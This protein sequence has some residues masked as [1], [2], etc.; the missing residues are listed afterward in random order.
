E[1]RVP[2][3]VNN[4]CH[5]VLAAPQQSMKDY[6]YKNTDA[7]EMIFIHEGEGVLHTMYGDLSF[8]YGDY[9]VIPRGTIYQ[10]EFAGSN[11]RLFIVESFSPIRYPKRY[12]SK[13]GQLLEHSP[14]CERDIRGPEAL[15][16]YDET[17]DFLIRAKKKGILYGLHYGTHPFDLIGW[18]G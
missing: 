9:L 5:I 10:I 18:D 2:V 15:K 11:N 4:D 16:T 12:L 17:G 3:L 8:S 6:F 14:Y 13:E 1:S 7:D